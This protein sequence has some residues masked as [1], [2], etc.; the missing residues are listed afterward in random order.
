MAYTGMRPMAFYRYLEFRRFIARMAPIWKYYR[1]V[2]VENHTKTEYDS[3][4]S[5]SAK[6]Q[7]KSDYSVEEPAPPISFTPEVPRYWV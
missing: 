2:S 6:R 1:W 7:N 3:P 4:P 5:H